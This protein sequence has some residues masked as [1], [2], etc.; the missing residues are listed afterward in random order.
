MSMS[1]QNNKKS[2]DLLNENKNA[3]NDRHLIFDVKRNFSAA[4]ISFFVVT[5]KNSASCVRY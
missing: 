2:F 1:V 4:I 5:K 3:K